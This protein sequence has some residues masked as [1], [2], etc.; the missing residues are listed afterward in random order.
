MRRPYALLCFLL[1]LSFSTCIMVRMTDRKPKW[2]VSKEQ[3]EKT[4]TAQSVPEEA[5]QT[6]PPPPPSEV[7]EMATPPDTPAAPPAFDFDSIRRR[8]GY[9]GRTGKD[10]RLL[11]HGRALCTDSSGEHVCRYSR[12]K[13]RLPHMPVP[14][15]RA[16]GELGRRVQGNY[17][18]GED[19]SV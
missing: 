3:E 7:P 6:T 4:K 5:P 15:Y 11:F 2:A 8:R 10:C 13:L 12:G 18:V 17:R 9:Y 1:L 14:I 16:D 19:W